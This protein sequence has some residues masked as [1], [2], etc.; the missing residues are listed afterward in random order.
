MKKTFFFISVLL[1]AAV[2]AQAAIVAYTLP[3][4]GV[5]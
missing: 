5:V 3:V 1:C 2:G 4:P